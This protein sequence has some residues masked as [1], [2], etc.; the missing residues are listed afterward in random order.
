M[1]TNLWVNVGF[2]S[3][4]VNPKSIT[5]G[6][7]DRCMFN[8]WGNGQTFFQSG[9]FSLHFHLRCTRVPFPLYILAKSWYFGYKSLDNVLCRCFP[10]DFL[11]C[12][13]IPLKVPCK[14]HLKILMKLNLLV[15][16]DCT[17]WIVL[18]PNPKLQRFYVFF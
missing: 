11:A 6:L 18:L 12:I 2:H 10:H 5:P 13:F 9:C 8:F 14:E 15:F 16:M 1:C 4:W 17:L 3:S 7:Y